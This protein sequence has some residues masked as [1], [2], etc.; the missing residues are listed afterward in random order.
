MVNKFK[1]GPVDLLN[2]VMMVLFAGTLACIASEA[3]A[4][5]KNA[6]S[7]PRQVRVLDP[8]GEVAE[9]WMCYS[10][11]NGNQTCIKTQRAEPQLARTEARFGGRYIEFK[12]RD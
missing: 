12:S 4:A 7:S 1:M 2:P 8:S 11:R 10:Y 9:L 3:C 6:N 5:Q